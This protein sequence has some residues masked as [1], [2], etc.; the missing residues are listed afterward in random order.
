MNSNTINRKVMQDRQNLIG[1][2]F[3][4]FFGEIW[5]DISA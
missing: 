3:A 2:T 1:T 4:L 5:P